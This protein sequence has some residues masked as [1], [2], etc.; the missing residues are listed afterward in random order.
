MYWVIQ[1]KKE[2]N[3]VSAISLSEDNWDGIICILEHLS[4][5]NWEK[6]APLLATLKR[7]FIL[8]EEVFILIGFN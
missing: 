7:R 8:H 5:P 3:H 4:N 1:N 6:S 2:S